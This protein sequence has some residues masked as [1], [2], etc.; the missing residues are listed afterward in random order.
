MPCFLEN[1]N[2]SYLYEKINPPMYTNIPYPFTCNPPFVSNT[3]L[4]KFN[5]QR[6]SPFT[7]YLCSFETPWTL[8]D[9]TNLPVVSL[10]IQGCGPAFYVFLNGYYIGYSTDTFLSSEFLVS[11]QLHWTYE[12]SHTTLSPK[13]LT[14]QGTTETFLESTTKVP[15]E[16]TTKLPFESTINSPFEITNKSFLESN[17]KTFLESTI[18]T[19]LESPSKVSLESPSKVPLESPSKVPLESPSKVPLDYGNR[20]T[21]LLVVPRWC[22]TSYLEDQDH[23]WFSGCFRDVELMRWPLQENNT[24]CNTK[25]SQH[26]NVGDRSETLCSVTNSLGNTTKLC[27]E[28]FSVSTRLTKTETTSNFR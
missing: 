12:E 22:A 17:T 7:C 2:I 4:S 16:S 1:T 14:L 3:L 9:K 13:K 23:W 19:P 20:N 25:E 15:L 28:D 6:G 8:T 11:S 10:I 18:K 27:I 24:F 21:L 5:H 26:N